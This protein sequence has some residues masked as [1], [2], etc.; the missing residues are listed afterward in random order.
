[1]A[2]EVNYSSMTKIYPQ[3]KYQRD[4]NHDIFF[5]ILQ[6]RDLK[7]FMESVKYVTEQSKQ[8]IPSLAKEGVMAR[9][10]MMMMKKQPFGIPL[11]HASMYLIH[12]LKSRVL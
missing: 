3:T 12:H 11:G 4:S 8:A 1:M 6:A 2:K 7:R 10:L 5:T 9:K